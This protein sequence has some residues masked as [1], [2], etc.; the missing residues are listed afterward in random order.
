MRVEMFELHVGVERLDAACRPMVLRGHGVREAIQVA[1]VAIRDL[2]D[3]HVS[4]SCQPG[5]GI[6]WAG[7]PSKNHHPMRRFDP[8]RIRLHLL[9]I[10]ERHERVVTVLSGS[11]A[12]LVVLKNHAVMLN[13]V[14]DKR[15][16]E[17]SIHHAVRGRIFRGVGSEGD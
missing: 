15:T 17:F 13:L 3:E 7:V 16:G 14:R 11:D 8:V 4:A 2:R 10:F 12:N 5:H 1:G 6:A 9:V